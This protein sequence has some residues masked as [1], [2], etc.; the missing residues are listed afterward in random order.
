VTVVRGHHAAAVDVAGARFVDN[1]DFAETGEAFSLA[2]AEESLVPGTLVAFGDIVLKRQL[3]Q[4]LLEDA[5]DGITLVV[6][7]TQAASAAPDRVRAARP[8]SGHLLFDEVW[9]AGIGDDVAPATGHGVWV[10]LLHAG[11]DGAAWLREAIAGARADA[12]LRAARL[13]DLIMRVL[14]A[15][16]PVRGVHVRGAWVDVDNRTDP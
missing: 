2:L 8:D 16:R 14:A 12:T 5:G 7:S 13:S 10:G 4:A 6:D 15:G 9:L 3:V 1:V 11:R